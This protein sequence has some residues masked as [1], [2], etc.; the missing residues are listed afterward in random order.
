[1]FYSKLLYPTADDPLPSQ[2]TTDPQ[3]VLRIVNNK[4]EYKVERILKEQL[5]Q[6]GRRQTKQ[7]LVK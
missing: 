5:V 3:L 2:R 6:K 1:M 4:E 7:Y